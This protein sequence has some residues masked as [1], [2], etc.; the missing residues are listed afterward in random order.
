[1]SSTTQASNPSRSSS[2]LRH[3]TGGS[4]HGGCSKG[5]RRN[6]GPRDLLRL[7][8]Q[9]VTCTS[10][11]TYLR[12]V[13]QLELIDVIFGAL[14]IKPNHPSAMEQ[15]VH[16]LQHLVGT[17]ILTHGLRRSRRTTDLINIAENAALLSAVCVK[18]LP[19]SCLMESNVISESCTN[20]NIR[21]SR[22]LWITLIVLR[23]GI[24]SGSTRCPAL[25]R[26][27]IM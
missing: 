8:T 4:Q 2:H 12:W 1:M 23:P 18:S 22:A 24:C 5:H 7:R 16:G 20:L 6:L 14:G 27:E 13:C 15:A 3:P 19:S 21:M 25:T 11:S 26:L 17:H 10:T 9:N